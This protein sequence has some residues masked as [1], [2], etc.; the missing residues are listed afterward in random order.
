MSSSTL[1][2]IEPVFAV[3]WPN[4]LSAEVAGLVETVLSTSDYDLCFD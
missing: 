3:V 2:G 4:S 1:N